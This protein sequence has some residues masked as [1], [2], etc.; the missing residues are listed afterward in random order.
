MESIS[1]SAFLDAQQLD[2]LFKQYHRSL[3]YFAKSMVRDQETAE[4]LVADS[5]V[6]LWQRRETFE[7]TDK[8]KAF[9]YI[10]TKNACLNH[11]NSAHARQAFDGEALDVL[12]SVDP[13]SY[14]QLVRAELMQQIYDEVMKLPEKQ[15]EVFR[16]TFFEDLDTDEIGERLGMTPTAIFAN[17]S[18][19]VEAL[20]KIFKD[21]KLYL[22]LFVLQEVIQKKSF[23]M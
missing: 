8:V 22:C 14:A 23:L 4:E 12:Q 15:R 1:S 10:A 2:A 16:L 3:L 19:A 5:F 6:K 11:L 13:D 7:N 18:R 21:K 9:L 20:R 17:R